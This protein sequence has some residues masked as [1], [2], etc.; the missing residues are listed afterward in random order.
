MGWL[1]MA[2][3]LASPFVGCNKKTAT[4]GE[5]CKEDGAV[6]CKDKQ[7]AFV[8]AS[9]KWEQISCR[10]NTGCMSMGANQNDNCT[11][12]SFEEKEPCFEKGTAYQCSVDKTLMLTCSDGRWTAVEKCLGQNGCQANA[13]GARCDMS[14]SEDGA[15]CS[16]ESKDT[17]SCTKDAKTML[18]CDGSK[19][20]AHARCPGMHGCRKQFDKIQCN[21]EERIQ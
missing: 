3:L 18:R 16:P 13:K 9:G 17:F 2:V 14:I 21:G 4:A 1:G 5:A 6:V 10:A 8:C 19:M 7:S 12:L 11:N 15:P 20:V